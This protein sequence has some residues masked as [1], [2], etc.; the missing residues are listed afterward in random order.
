MEILG[1][2]S[3]IV[4]LKLKFYTLEDQTVV[5]KID[6]ASSQACFLAFIV[7]QTNMEEI[8]GLEEKA[9][10]T[11]ELNTRLKESFPYEIQEK[12]KVEDGQT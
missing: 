3:L 11:P 12:Q 9:E 1:E 8:H 5:L 4:H 6:S 7:K 2:V 10:G